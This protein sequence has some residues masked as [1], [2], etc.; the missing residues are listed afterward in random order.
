MWSKPDFAKKG[1]KGKPDFKGKKIG[2]W[3]FG[4]EF[5]VFAAIT[6]A[7]LDPAADVELVQ[8]QFDMQGLLPFL[9]SQGLTLKDV[10]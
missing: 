4:N 1:A 7:G 3:G 6:K 10:I 2:N 5:E 9:K 8:Q